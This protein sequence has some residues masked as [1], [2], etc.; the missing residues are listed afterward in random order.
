MYWN[1]FSDFMAMGQHG[2]YVWGA[3]GGM[4]GLMLLE[5]L[6]LRW[7]HRQCVLHLKRQLHAGPGATP[8]RSVP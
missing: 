7:R 3:A 8:S 1:S 5:P 6:F 2:F 4:A